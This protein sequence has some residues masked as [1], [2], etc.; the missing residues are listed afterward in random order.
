MPKASARIAATYVFQDISRLHGWSQA[1]TTREL[2]EGVGAAYSAF[3]SQL[4]DVCRRWQAEGTVQDSAEPAEVAEL[5]LSVVLGF[6]AQK[7]LMGQG[8]AESHA[9]GFSAPARQGLDATGLTSAL[10]PTTRVQL[11]RRSGM[12]VVVAPS[13]AGRIGCSSRGGSRTRTWG[14]R[15]SV[16]RRSQQ[17]ETTSSAST[18]TVLSHLHTHAT[19]AVPGGTAQRRAASVLS[20]R[21]EKVLL[22][23]RF[24]PMGADLGTKGPDSVHAHADPGIH[25][26][27]RCSEN[28]LGAVARLKESVLTMACD[29]ERDW[30]ARRSIPGRGGACHRGSADPQLAWPVRDGRVAVAARPPRATDLRVPDKAQRRRRSRY[31][32]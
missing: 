23:H 28:P 21:L 29:I 2:K 19:T 14:S 16:A 22:A 4:A 17:T 3:R 1:Q 24:E 18:S 8:N 30:V 7:A 31:G 25:R 15:E 5:L 32:A 10:V 9:S 13:P 11:D 20:A 27:I 12:L 6:V 26:L